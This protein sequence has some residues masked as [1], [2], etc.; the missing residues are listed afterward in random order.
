MDEKKKRS[1][2]VTNEI[3]YK[4]ITKQYFFAF[5][6]RCTLFIRTFRVG[7]YVFSFFTCPFFKSSQ[8]VYFGELLLLQPIAQQ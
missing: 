6:F 2:M 1:N 7:P 4:T 5:F 8:A 3:A